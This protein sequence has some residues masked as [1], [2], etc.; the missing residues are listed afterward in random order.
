MENTI[1]F[2]PLIERVREYGKSSIELYKLKALE[3]SSAITSD[4]LSRCIALFILSFFIL[5]VS[6]GAAFWLGDLLGKTYLG[7]LG[8]GAFYGF[9]GILL[10][11]VF[12][13]SIKARLNNSIISKISR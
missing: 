10:Y 7:F 13:D 11:F 8:V 6:I 5:M 12:H 9:A 4:F 3:K 1:P 2:E